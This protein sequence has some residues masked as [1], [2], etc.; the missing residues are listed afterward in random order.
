MMMETFD[1]TETMK[2]RIGDELVK[3]GLEDT[4]LGDV[5]TDG[6]LKVRYTRT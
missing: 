2:G 3:V 4:M 5:A 6:A 1:G